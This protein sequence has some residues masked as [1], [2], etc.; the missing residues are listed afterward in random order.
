MFALSASVMNVRVAR[1]S[2][3]PGCQTRSTA[4]GAREIEQPI[5]AERGLRKQSR[6]TADRLWNIS[7]G[8]HFENLAGYELVRRRLPDQH[9]LET[10]AEPAPAVRRRVLAPR[11]VAERA[12]DGRLT[13]SLDRGSAE[14][15]LADCI[16]AGI[17]VR[18]SEV[19]TPG[20]TPG[21]CRGGT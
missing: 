2:S 6:G 14:E 5:A 8:G 19:H 10:A 1:L 18:R 13:V 7:D 4:T 16:R 17:V 15:V 9:V 21:S 20:A 12:S 11:H 3:D